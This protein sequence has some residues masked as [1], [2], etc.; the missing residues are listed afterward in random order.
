MENSGQ[1]Q[2]S[3]LGGSQTV[4]NNHGS[5]ADNHGQT[6][7]LV[8]APPPAMMQ[9]AERRP[10]ELTMHQI[11]SPN[12]EIPPTTPTAPTP[13]QLSPLSNRAKRAWNPLSPD[14][15]PGGDQQRRRGFEPPPG[16]ARAD[17][18][19]MA[20]LLKS[21]QSM[22]DAFKQLEQRNLLLENECRAM[23]HE[24][25]ENF[26][27]L[28]NSM[29]EKAALLMRHEGIMCDNRNYT[30]AKF[31]EVFNEIKAHLNE[32]NYTNRVARIEQIVEKHHLTLDH[33]YTVKPD[34]GNEILHG[35]AAVD[36]HIRQL[37]RARDQSERAF[38]HAITGIQQTSQNLSTIVNANGME[39]QKNFDDLRTEVTILR[40]LIDN[41]SPPPAYPPGC[42]QPARHP[43]QHGPQLCGG[44]GGYGGCGGS[45]DCNPG[46]AH[47]YGGCG[48]SGDGNPGGSHH[49]DY[50]SGGYAPR[51]E[52]C[53][54]HH[55]DK[56]MQEVATLSSRT[57]RAP[58]LPTQGNAG[59]PAGGPSEPYA[60]GNGASE[61]R[62]GDPPNGSPMQLPLQLGV[63]GS[64]A[65]GRVFDDKISVHEDFRFNGHKNGHAWKFK[66]ER[67]FIT[68][69]PALCQIL[70][71]AE[72]EE[73][74]ISHDRLKIATGNSLSTV[75]RDGNYIDHT[76]ALNTA[77]WG[78]LGNCITGEADVM[79]KQAAQ[80]NGIDAWRRIV[81]FIDSGRDI[82]LEQLRQEVRMIRS[83]PIKNLE[84]VTI[85]IAA[86]ENKIRDY[87]E[88]GG[89]AL[90][91][92][93]MK[94][95]LNAILPHEL[96][97]YLI[98]R[99]TDTHQTYEAFRDHAVQA[100][101]QLLM[102]KKRLP[103][104]HVREEDTADDSE[105]NAED[106]AQ[107]SSKEELDQMYLAA[108]NRFQRRGRPGGAG[109]AGGA[110]KTQPG[111]SARPATAATGNRASKCTN[112]GGDHAVSSCT[113]PMQ[114][115]H[116]PLAHPRPPHQPYLRRRP[117]N[118]KTPKP[119]N[120][121]FS[122][123][124]MRDSL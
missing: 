74:P 52:K 108:V 120:P 13:M 112:C 31:N 82:R 71:W 81:R 20:E 48:G 44:Y 94:S 10:H 111:N 3:H 91:Q 64:L 18:A 84:A 89:R 55:V 15:K 51:N 40:S 2:S 65:S 27:E 46:G 70:R 105:P 72:R 75:D 101:A 63:H 98:V 87:V 116:R 97:D 88:A 9:S 32:E 83:F 45:G 58:F 123:V 107:A 1:T 90:P 28:K 102:R 73:N 99:V 93:E 41:A 5:A 86:F 8:Q 92:D 37:N 106:F 122:N 79:Y 38:A 30:T 96:S 7:L 69:V 35:F 117:Q 16:P 77:V 53:H 103:V 11:F 43:A 61:A 24:C 54:C 21:M 118:P 4:G 50:T 42:G 25:L 12:S 95:D 114:H 29:A 59:G 57:A 33:L 22:S 62:A 26:A 36:E 80:C 23:Q 110:R 121:S 6:G 76:E 78:F 124:I 39:T 34:E 49:W 47:G 68:K 85:G 109:G 113:K 100:C 56:L 14:A 67:Y 66:T 119:Q 115:H 19:Y 60:P 104:N 17:E